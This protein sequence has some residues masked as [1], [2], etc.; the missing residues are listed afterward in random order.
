M[1]ILLNR[2]NTLEN[3]L[4]YNFMI[5]GINHGD[6]YTHSIMRKTMHIYSWYIRYVW[7][8]FI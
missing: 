3:Y 8:I 6:G 1:T 4:K 2:I 5:D 7:I